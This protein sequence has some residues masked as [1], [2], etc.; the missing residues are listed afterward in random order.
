MP[1]IFPCH[2]STDFLVKCLIS[3]WVEFWESVFLKHKSILSI[4]RVPQARVLWTVWTSASGKC[5][6]RILPV[7]KLHSLIFASR[8]NRKKKSKK[9]FF[10]EYFYVKRHTVLLLNIDIRTGT[11]CAYVRNVRIYR[12]H[13]KFVKRVHRA[14]WA[15][16]AKNGPETEIRRLLQC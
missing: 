14:Q 10:F 13:Q 15:N 12:Q 3:A 11:L 2:F 5:F 6:P 9:K 1:E 7:L 16:M 4:G 8:S